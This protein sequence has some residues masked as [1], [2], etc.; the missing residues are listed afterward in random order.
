MSKQPDGPRKALG[1]GLSALLPKRSG[2]P[3][4]APETDA[5]PAQGGIAAVKVDLIDPNRFQPRSVFAP[6]R[7]DE[8]VA[9]IQANGI[10][11]PLIV[12]RQ[13]DRYELIAGERRLRAAKLAGIEAVP[14]VVRDASDTDLLQLA[15]VENIQR[16]DLNPIE[17]AQAL[18][19]LGRD[20]GLTHEEI[21]SRTGKDRATVSNLLR[22][23]KLPEGVQLLVAEERLSM[24]HARAILGLP[25]AE[26]QMQ[27]AMKA[28]DEDLS[29]R[30]VEKLVKQLTQPAEPAAEKKPPATDDPN[31]KAAVLDM[32]RALGTRVRIVE[33]APSRGRI[34]IEYYSGEELDRLY[35]VLSGRD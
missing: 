7:L 10:I 16:E 35:G 21:G 2:V 29:V 9:S 34:E 23:L 3:A 19:R 28:A 27:V 32:E 5:H 30:Q 18:E 22:L 1:K 8:L 24:G 33:R 25:D 20:L 11:Q 6:E 17:L 14:V 12:Q 31:F 13:A 26:L 4:T 15:L